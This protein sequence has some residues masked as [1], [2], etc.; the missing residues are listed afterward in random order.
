VVYRTPKPTAQEDHWRR[1]TA[2]TKT[3]LEQLKIELAQVRADRKAKLQA[4]IENL[5]KRINAKLARA[6][7]RS[8]QAT[9]EYQAKVEALQQKADKEK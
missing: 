6:Q 3:Q 9:R 1:E 4:Q 2:N 8:E 5:S 7:A